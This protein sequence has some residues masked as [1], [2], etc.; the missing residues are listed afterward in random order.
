[1]VPHRGQW[2][3]MG[4]NSKYSYAMM[5]ISIDMDL[6]CVDRELVLGFL[7]ELNPSVPN[8]IVQQ[9][10][11][12]SIYIFQVD[13]EQWQRLW[14]LQCYIWSRIQ[15]FK[16]GSWQKSKNL[17]ETEVIP[18]YMVLYVPVSSSRIE[19]YDGYE[20]NKLIIIFLIRQPTCSS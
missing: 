7:N 6:Y 12:Q 3:N 10:Q 13:L 20:N 11:C 8:D 17:W 18:M 9:F 16:K 1:M 2:F 15:I 5:Q 19:H 14:P 4:K